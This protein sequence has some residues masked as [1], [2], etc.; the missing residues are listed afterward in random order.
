MIDNNQPLRFG[1]WN[2]CSIV[3]K[4]AEVEALLHQHNLD[5]LAI[6]ETWLSDSV[7]VWEVFGF[8]T[9]RSDRNS[10]GGGTLLLIRDKIVVNPIVFRSDFSE[11]FNAVGV[12]IETDLGKRVII[13][14]YAPPGN[15]IPLQAWLGFF[16]EFVNLCPVII[17]GD[18]NAHSFSWG[19]SFNSPRGSD[20]KEVFEF[21]NL[22]PLNDSVPTRIDRAG[23]TN[24]NVD[25][26]VVSDSLV[27][28]VSCEVS[29]D[30]YGSDHLLVLANFDI[31]P[32]FVGSN[33]TRI[34]FKNVDWSSIEDLF[35]S[36]VGDLEVSLEGGTPPDQVYENLLSSLIGILEDNG[37][38]KSTSHPGFRKVEPLW[39]DVECERAIEKRR[40][41]RKDWLYDQ[42]DFLRNRYKEIDQEVKWFLRKKKKD[43][44]IHY[45]SSISPSEDHNKIWKSV[46]SFLN[47]NSPSHTNITNDIDSETFK[48]LKS[49]LVNR[50]IPPE[51][52]PPLTEEYDQGSGN[53]VFNLPFSLLEFS[54]ALNDCKKKSAPGLASGSIRT[55]NV[56]YFDL[57]WEMLTQEFRFI[58]VNSVELKSC[59]NPDAWLNEFL[60][61]EIGEGVRV[62]SDGAKGKN[63]G[64]SSASY[65]VPSLDIE[66]GV[67]LSNDCS[68]ISAELYGIFSALKFVLSSNLKSFIVLSD[69]KLSLECIKDVFHTKSPHPL[70]LKVKNLLFEILSK[71]KEINFVWIPS[72]SGISGNLEADRIAKFFLTLELE[73]FSGTPLCD[74]KCIVEKRY[75]SLYKEHW[76][77]ERKPGSAI[78]YFGKV[79]FESIRP[80]FVGIDAPRRSINT[81]TRMRTSAPVNTLNVWDGIWI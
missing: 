46:K 65:F 72:H 18:F 26:I 78:T 1:T 10:F 45:C 25:L 73:R 20:L 9:F 56:A 50:D 24:N 37:A 76:P 75:Q 70:V 51:D 63:N 68:I 14:I 29:N 60:L 81:F 30:S 33:S 21:Y 43:S 58:S 61:T 42:S 5:V 23:R 49:E 44:F 17:C 11:F 64:R 39:W 31:R 32:K 41:A 59:Q 80:W 35:S 27:S 38:F 15:N 16:N 34:N 62:F 74:Y 28:Q 57:S 6:S 47:K 55:D 13:S 8:N 3:N 36:L 71:N 66:F 52:S 54:M 48:L 4:K 69:S 19:A 22:L 2:A 40:E 67:R 7:P 53:D 77:Y 12:M 79:R